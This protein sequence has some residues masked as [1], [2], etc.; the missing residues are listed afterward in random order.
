MKNI[1]FTMLFRKIVYLSFGF[2]LNLSAQE[3]S[4]NSIAVEEIIVTAR[5]RAESIQD[6]PVA[7]SALSVEQ[8]EIEVIFKEFKI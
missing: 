3:E 7:V 1:V 5:K 8:I 4:V 6:V 2:N